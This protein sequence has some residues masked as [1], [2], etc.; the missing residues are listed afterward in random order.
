MPEKT[1]IESLLFICACGSNRVKE[2]PEPGSTVDQECVGP[3]DQ[4]IHPAINEPRPVLSIGLGGATVHEVKHLVALQDCLIA[5]VKLARECAKAR[6]VYA[7]P[8]TIIVRV[9]STPDKH[10]RSCNNGCFTGNF[11]RFLTDGLVLHFR[12]I[13]LPAIIFSSSCVAYG[14]REIGFLYDMGLA[15]RMRA[16]PGRA[17]VMA[18]RVRFLRRMARE[19]RAG[20]CRNAGPGKERLV[21]L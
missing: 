7:P 5:R 19:M 8:G 12:L 20:G 6:G 17:K 2:N 1:G 18:K 4:L 11:G 9:T 21:H 14:E 13:R 16:R 10:T 3:G 15:G